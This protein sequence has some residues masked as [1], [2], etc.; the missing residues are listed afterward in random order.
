MGQGNNQRK[1]RILCNPLPGALSFSPAWACFHFL[2]EV[3]WGGFDRWDGEA[4]A[5]NQCLSLYFCQSPWGFSS[6]LS[7]QHCFKQGA[8][9]E[10]QQLEENG[11]NGLE[12]VWIPCRIAMSY[13]GIACR[14]GREFAA[15]SGSACL[16]KVGQ[17][18]ICSYLHD[19]RQINSNTSLLQTP[20]NLKPVCSV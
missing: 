5:E 16:I 9:V 6:W 1:K 18:I 14:K 12:E 13:P 3:G 20:L 7:L 19:R 15:V 10:L 2:I 4:E 11:S 8:R 17:G